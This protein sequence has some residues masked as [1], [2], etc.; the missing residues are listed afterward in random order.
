MVRT[1]TANPPPPPAHTHIAALSVK[2]TRDEAGRYP[3]FGLLDHAILSFVR[4]AFSQQCST[5]NLH[6]TE[7]TI[8][9]EVTISRTV[10]MKKKGSAL[11][12][13]RIFS[14]ERENKMSILRNWL[15]QLSAG[16]IVK[17]TS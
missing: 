10:S 7:T 1:V 5:F 15:F 6:T 8:H 3:V 2:G 9:P 13:A 16:I 11:V 14:R 4:R 17:F 12:V